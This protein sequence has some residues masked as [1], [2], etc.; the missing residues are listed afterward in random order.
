MASHDDSD[1]F[2]TFR[3]DAEQ[4]AIATQQPA[5]G[6]EVRTAASSRTMQQQRA[7]TCWQSRVCLASIF[8]VV[9]LS[10]P[11]QHMAPS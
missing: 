5:R 4:L 11:R 8:A 9:A 6:A 3:R 2:G 10:D 7:T 1:A